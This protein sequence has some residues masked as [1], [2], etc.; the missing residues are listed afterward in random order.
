MEGTVTLPL[1]PVTRGWEEVLKGQ[2]L[3]SS[4][5]SMD[6]WALHPNYRC[7]LGQIPPP[8]WASGSP[9]VQQEG[10]SQASV[11]SGDAIIGGP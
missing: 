2:Q 4:P 6:S 11:D 10:W 3:W 7:D 9:P 1:S 8:G 5:E